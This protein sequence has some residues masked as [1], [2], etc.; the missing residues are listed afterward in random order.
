MGEK[1]MAEGEGSAEPPIE[2]ELA[3]LARDW[4]TLWQSELAAL[5]ADRETQE[6]WQKLISLWAGAA[7][8]FAAPV[9]DGAGRRDA[10]HAAAAAARSAPAAPT[11]DAR[12]AEI[13]RLRG[14]VDA[15]ERRLAALEQR[16]RSGRARRGGSS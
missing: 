2:T 10:A 14:R 8:V 16:P 9:P 11:P 12:D 7:R 1:A 3:A 6:A 15:L 5:A 13:E 4:M